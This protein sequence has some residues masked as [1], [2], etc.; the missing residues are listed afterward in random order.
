M[1]L[2]L[3]SDWDIPLQSPLSK[4]ETQG[5][6]VG[7]EKE[8]QPLIHEISRKKNGSILISGYRGVGKTSLV[9]K[10]LSDAKKKNKNIIIVLINAAQLEAEPN[11]Q[12]IDPRKIIENLIRRLYSITRDYDFKNSGSQDLKNNNESSK[13]NTGFEK[14]MEKIKSPFATRHSDLNNYEKLKNDI[15]I[16][17]RKAIASEFKIIE[18]TCHSQEFSKEI[19]KE[20]KT[21]ISLTEV[22]LKNPFFLF[23]F[24]VALAFQFI[25]LTSSEELNKVFP[26][27]LAFPIPFVLNMLY[28]HLE[29][30]KIS[31]EEERKTKKLYEID[32]SIGNLEFDLEN[33]HRKISDKHN[34]IYIIDELD[35]LNTENANDVLKFF[36]NLFT[37]SNALFIFIAGEEM[38]KIQKNNNLYRP[39]EYTYF[40]SKYCISR[41]LV[42]DLDDYFN[43]ICENKTEDY[44]SDFDSLKRAL[45][46]E[47]ENDFFDLKKCIKDRITSFDENDKP[48]IEIEKINYEDIQKARLHKAITILFEENYLSSNQSKWRENEK[49]LR[50]LFEYVS[51]IYS[52]YSGK[53]FKDPSDDSISSE[54][55]RDFNKLLLELKAFNL[56]GTPEEEIIKGLKVS[57]RKYQYIGNIPNDPTQYSDELMEYE[58]R[59]V[60]K[61]ETFGNYILELNN[62]LTK[63]R[64]NKNEV[65]ESIFW[66]CPTS[67]LSNIDEWGFHVSDLFNQYFNIYNDIVNQKK[68]HLYTR[69]GIEEITV[70]IEKQTSTLLTNLPKIVGH[71]LMTLHI[72]LDP[73]FGLL[74]EKT[75]LFN[76][77]HDDIHNSLLTYNPSIITFKRKPSHQI[78]LINDNIDFIQQNKNELEKKYL[79]SWEKIS[80]NDDGKLI[81][82]LMQ[83]FSIEWIKAAKIN[84]ND[85]GKTISVT[86]DTNS[87]SLTLNNKKTKVNLEID[88]GRTD[89]FIVKMEEGELKIY[90]ENHKTHRIFCFTD[91]S[92]DTMITD[93]VSVLHYINIESPEKLRESIIVSFSDIKKFLRRIVKY[94]LYKISPGNII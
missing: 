51:D 1:K 33:I 86:N 55:K 31:E 7:R 17:Y 88:D 26:L 38:C 59:F 54:M 90:K 18:S 74:Q 36:K 64:H 81:E 83:N 87:L 63:S 28:K 19:L 69:E 12:S 48:I 47:A 30:S 85:D 24:V 15:E 57:I 89:E 29:R 82:F 71:M 84:K 21:E 10:A 79:F 23:F 61:F 11:K 46:L 34:L 72:N 44:N 94:P 60:K 35:K 66:K 75:S 70:K 56:Q 80:G 5:H 9:Y 22:N 42:E 67:F 13:R 92:V 78:L 3:K 65:S 27:L 40:T 49:L 52:S 20:K 37:L 41:P 77:F 39:K 45:F 16:L 25:G 68:D 58:A 73:E 32:N 93:E 6:F 62:A 2:T 43:N 14:L 53:Q 76:I 4:K 91:S 8:L 50:E